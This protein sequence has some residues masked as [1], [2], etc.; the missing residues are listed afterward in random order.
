MRSVA[1]QPSFFAFTTDGVGHLRARKR[2]NSR[3]PVKIYSPFEIAS[4]IAFFGRLP[5]ASQIDLPSIDSSLH[6]AEITINGEKSQEGTER[7]QTA[8]AKREGSSRQ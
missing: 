2:T 1:H 5:S 3:E 4:M 7:S 6:A 8:T